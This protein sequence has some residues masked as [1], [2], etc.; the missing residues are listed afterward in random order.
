MVAYA[1]QLFKGAG[2]LVAAYP[3]AQADEGLWFL[4]GECT[5]P[6]YA[7]KDAAVPLEERLC[8]IRVM[9]TVFEQ[10][11]VPRC[12][13]HLTQSA[14]VSH[15]HLRRLRKLAVGLDC[16]PRTIMACQEYRLLAI[17][18]RAVDHKA[19]GFDSQLHVQ[20]GLADEI[21]ASTYKGFFAMVGVGML[22]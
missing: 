20:E 13:P 1:T 8:C 4:V 11:F 17:D 14:R 15:L 19:Q 16:L 2:E 21:V 7:L 5:S 22:A 12:T 3:D 18:P 10:C 6:L 9:T